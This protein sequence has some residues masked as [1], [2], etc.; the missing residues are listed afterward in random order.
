MSEL[1]EYDIIP[2]SE[3]MN[4]YEFTEREL[5]GFASDYEIGIAFGF[6]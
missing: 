3:F 6:R 2:D 4:E 1:N 5:C